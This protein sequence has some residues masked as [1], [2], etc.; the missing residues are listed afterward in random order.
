[1]QQ[2]LVR[3]ECGQIEH[4]PVPTTLAHLPSGHERR[5]ASRPSGPPYLQR[6]SLRP[7]PRTETGRRNRL[8]A[9]ASREQRNAPALAIVLQ[10][11]RAAKGLAGPRHVP[12][13]TRVVPRAATGE[14][15]RPVTRTDVPGNVPGGCPENPNVP[16]AATWICGRVN[17]PEHAV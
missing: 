7:A 9:P 1:V 2:R 17:G 4:P 15:N 12:R 6:L 14:T 16:F 10:L 13:V 8:I 3:L 5:E 11:R